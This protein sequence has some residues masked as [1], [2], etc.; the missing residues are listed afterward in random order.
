MNTIGL[1]AK[2]RDGGELTGAEI[3]QLIRGY[4]DG[5]IPDYQMSALAMAIYLQGMSTAETAAL[6]DHMLASGDQF[7]WPTGG[8]PKSINIQ[9]VASATRCRCRW[10]RCWPVVAWPCR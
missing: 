8:I 9:P 1:I 2:K 7:Q 10:R 6:T 5:E 4:V 3:G